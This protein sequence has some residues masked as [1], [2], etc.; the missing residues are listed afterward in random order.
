MGNEYLRAFVIGSSFF[1]IFP[2]FYSVS[3]FD[4]KKTNFGYIPYTYFAPIGLGFLNLISLIIAHLFNLTREQRYFII[5]LLAPTFVLSLI[6]ILK[7]YNYTRRE[8]YSHIIGLYSMYFFV[9][10]FVLYILDKYV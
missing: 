7:A 6:T 3:H 8:W 9:C 1:V 10:N 4:P 5:S 2:F